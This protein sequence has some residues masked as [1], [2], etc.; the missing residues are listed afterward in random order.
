MRGCVVD[1]V[2][3]LKLQLPRCFNTSDFMFLIQIIVVF[4]FGLVVGSFATTFQYRLPR[5][6]TPY[7]FNPAFSKPPFCSHCKHPLRFWEYLPMFGWFFVRGS[8]NYC[9]SPISFLHT[10]L[11]LSIG[12]WAV[13]CM[14][15][16]AGN[17]DYYI[18][19]FCLGV[20]C[21][22]GGFIIYEHQMLPNVITASIAI[23]AAIFYTLLH[24]TITYAITGLSLS[25]MLSLLFLMGQSKPS[26]K[27]KL[28]V[29]IIFSFLVWIVPNFLIVT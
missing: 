17:M 8:C 24:G 16:F 20:S 18:I 7:G 11:E 9:G 2:Y 19:F 21:L 22:L 5:G 28:I 15:F 23:E 25:V 14:L 1:S 29:A 26:S 6:V 3:N 12:L 13:I 4:L 10:L 27:Q